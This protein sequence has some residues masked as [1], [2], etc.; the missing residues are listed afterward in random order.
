MASSVSS[1]SPVATFPQPPEDLTE[2]VKQLAAKV[3]QLTYD[4]GKTGAAINDLRKELE[5]ERRA[6]LLLEKRVAH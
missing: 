3:V 4:L 1:N 5:E 6:R 2:Q